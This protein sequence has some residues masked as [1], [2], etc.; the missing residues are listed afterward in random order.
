MKKIDKNNTFMPLMFFFY[1]AAFCLYFG[2]IVSYLSAKGFGSGYIGLVITLCALI[3][4]VTQP[5]FGYFSETYLPT[6]YIM[7]GIC[8]LSIP[9]GFMLPYTVSV[10][11]MAGSAVVLLSVLE[12]PGFPISDMWSVK[13]HEKYGAISFGFVRSCG[14][15]GYA[16]AALIFGKIFNIIGIDYMFLFHGI[17]LLITVFILFPISK[18]SC[19]NKKEKESNSSSISM[20][21]AIKILSKN[22]KYVLFL[23]SFMFINIGMRFIANFYPVLIELKGGTVGQMGVGIFLMAVSEIPF[24]WGFNKYSKLFKI[25]KIMLFALCMFTVRNLSMLLAPN[26]FF[27]QLA[28]IT[29][30]ISFG[31]YVPSLL[32]YMSYITPRK[33]TTT[34]VTIVSSV[35]G[36]VSSVIGT[37]LG[38][39]MM[40]K[41]GA[42]QSIL[43]CVILSAV[44]AV[45]FSTSLAVPKTSYPQYEE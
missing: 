39:I 15:L 27:L 44:G 41:V 30:G 4:M 25:E 37:F 34:A 17:V 38:G 20:K 3:N 29:Q 6:K 7:F 14:S 11:F 40:E 1:N 16:L 42:Y 32:Y 43:V 24:I 10:P 26:I 33:I 28:Q 23:A 45:I 21:D 22:K 2:F 19:E 13:L 12:Y 36:A 35:V 5:I 8:L 31:I 18:V 9:I